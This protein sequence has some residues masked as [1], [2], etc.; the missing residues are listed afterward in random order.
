MFKFQ[1]KNGKNEKVGN[2][3][4]GLQNRTITGL[5]IGADFRDYKLWWELLQI[6]AALGISS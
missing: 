1:Y 5:E 4:T 6:G 3:F 2:T